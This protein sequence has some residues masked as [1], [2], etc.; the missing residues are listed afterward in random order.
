MRD[1]L[2]LFLVFTTYILAIGS[3]VSLGSEQYYTDQL[4]IQ[5]YAIKIPLSSDLTNAILRKVR[6]DRNGR[7]LVLSNQGVL[8]VDKEKLVRDRQYRPLTD[9]QIRDFDIYQDQ[10]VY[11]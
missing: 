5:D 1:K 9:M 3:V 7:I 11:T 4:F 10:F 2:I 8:Q 6:T